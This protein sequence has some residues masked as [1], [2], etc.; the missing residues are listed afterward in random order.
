MEGDLRSL[1]GDTRAT[2]VVDSELPRQGTFPASVRPHPSRSAELRLIQSQVLARVPAGPAPGPLPVPGHVDQ[3]QVI[4][5]RAA[6]IP[7]HP[8]KR[9]LDVTVAAA[10]LLLL[11]PVL[12][13]VGILVLLDR[14]GP[15]LFL[16][17]RGGL[18]GSV[19]RICKFRTMVVCD[20]GER[21]AQTRTGDWRITRL[22]AFLRRTSIDELPQLINVLLGDMSLVGP[23]PHAAAHDRVFAKAL[24]GYTARYQVR[25]GITGLAQV[26]GQ[27][28]AIRTRHQLARRVASD[29]EYIEQW[30]VLADLRILIASFTIVFRSDGA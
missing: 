15:V 27:R 28:G 9:C 16:Q 21:V 2:L 14:H 1:L 24:P 23:R 25:P 22:G 19:F 29:L 17:R 8:V 18:D 6:A 3:G 7:R 26:R 5:A 10:L 20:D 4:A 11:L 13:C 30:S 12:F